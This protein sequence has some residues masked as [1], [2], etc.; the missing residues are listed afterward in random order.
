MGIDLGE[1][2][3]TQACAELSYEIDTEI[4]K[5]LNDNAQYFPELEWNK[6]LPVG[7]SKRDHYAGFVEVIEIASQLIYDRTQ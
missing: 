3:A 5:L 4:V 2:L 6:A 7:V 1:V